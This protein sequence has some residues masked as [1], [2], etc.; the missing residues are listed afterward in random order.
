MPTNQSTRVVLKYVVVVLLILCIA[1]TASLFLVREGLK[2]KVLQ[3]TKITSPNGIESLEQVTLGGVKQ[4]ILIRGHDRSNPV[5][6]FLHG[7]PGAADIFIARHFD[8]ALVPHFTMVH[9]DQRGAGKSYSSRIPRES[10][11]RDQYISDIRELSEILKTR[12]DTPKVYLVGHSW[13]TEIGILAASRYPE[14]F[15]AY[16]GVAQVVDKAEQE[17][18][19]YQFVL[20]MATES[21]NEM[22]RRELAEIG[23]PPYADFKEQG[24]QRKWLEHYGGVSHNNAIGFMDFL[25]IGLTCPDYSLLDGLRFFRGQGF[26][27]KHMWEERLHTNLFQEVPRIEIPIYFFVGRHDYNTPFELAERYYEQLEAPKGK[28]LIWFENAAHMIPYESSEEYANTLINKVL[29][30]TYAK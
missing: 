28:Q 27:E 21:Q 5:L 8:T 7:G 1:A 14:L 13:G 24:I 11:K 16:V 2:Q 17:Q 19:S 20:D 4:W 6:L 30:E 10:I 15:H 25:K 3:E 18:I 23:P 9:W 22:A 29:K 12:F 26:S